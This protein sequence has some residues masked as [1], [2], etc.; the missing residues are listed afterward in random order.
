LG[1][2]SGF[3]SFVAHA[4]GP[5]LSA[6]VLPMRLDP[7]RVTATTAV[8]FSAV[9]MAK[10]LPYAALGLLDTRNLWTSLVLAPLAPVGVWA[11]VWMSRRTASDWFYRVAYTG[12]A[13]AGGKLLWDGWRAL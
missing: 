6:Y 13:A 1:I 2:V 10:W 4:G 12:M 7:M 9:N 3:T 5:P 11:G 8:F